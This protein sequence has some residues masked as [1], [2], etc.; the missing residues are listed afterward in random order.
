M[1]RKNSDNSLKPVWIFHLEYIY[2]YLILTNVK[3]PSF[4]LE[5]R[6]ELKK[7]NKTI[8][9]SSTLNYSN[10]GNWTAKDT[11][12]YHTSLYFVASPDVWPI[13]YMLESDRKWPQ[14]LSPYITMLYQRQ[15]DS[16]DILHSTNGLHLAAVILLQSR[17]ATLLRFYSVLVFGIECAWTN[18]QQA[19][20]PPHLS[21]R[22]LLE[23]TKWVFTSR[24]L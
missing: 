15:T 23:N 11:T 1:S 24:P 10:P 5:K 20:I 16:F 9:M 4:W 7:R 12:H 8:T 17:F 2:I 6:K 3:K 19:H 13:I 14:I 22:N 21:Y 18:L